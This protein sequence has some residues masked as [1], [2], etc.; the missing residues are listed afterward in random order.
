V[1]APDDGTGIVR[2]GS[3]IDWI[4]GHQIADKVLL[5][6]PAEKVRMGK[7]ERKEVTTN[8]L[9]KGRETNLVGEAAQFR[10]HAFIESMRETG[11]KKKAA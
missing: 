10:N 2:E 6:D 1:Y 9:P 5:P 3:G 8:R 4:F 11:D 7:R